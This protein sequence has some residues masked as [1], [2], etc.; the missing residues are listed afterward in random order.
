MALDFI[1]EDVWQNIHVKIETKIMLRWNSSCLQ[2]GKVGQWTRMR[3]E[4][5]LFGINTHVGFS[6]QNSVCIFV[7]QNA[8][9]SN[10]IPS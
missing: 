6:L 10:T 8:T 3:K 5:K 9:Q 2:L 7:L 4:N 1:K